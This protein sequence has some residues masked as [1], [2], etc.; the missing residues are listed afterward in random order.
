MF[1]VDNDSSL[2]CTVCFKSPTLWTKIERSVVSFRIVVF[3]PSVDGGIR[4]VILNCVLW[5]W[6]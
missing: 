4:T 2:K 5:R 6:S 3:D 1:V